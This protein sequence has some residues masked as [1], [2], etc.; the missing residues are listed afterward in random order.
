MTKSTLQ[1]IFQELQDH[2]D[3]VIHWRR[4]LHQH[5]E[6]SFQEFETA[7][8]IKEKLQSFGLEI[9]TNIGGNG[10]IAILNGQKK[11]PT[12]GLRADFDALPINDG[13]DVPYKSK[14][15]GVMHACGHDGHTAALLGTAR[16]LSKY[17]DKISGS[18]IFIFQHAEEKPPGGAKAM[19]EELNIDEID[20]IF[21]AHLASDIPIGK[22][23]VGAGFKMAAVDK[24]EI[25]VHGKGGHGAKPQ[26]TND[27]IVIGSD[28]VN[29]FQKI[30]SRRVDPLDSAVVTLGV[31]HAGN[32]FNV[33]P[34][35]ARLEGTV[36]SFSEEVRKQVK[37]NIYSLVKGIT[38][39]YQASFNI[40]YL[41]GYPALYNPQ[42][43][44]AVITQ[45]FTELLGEENVVEFQT[46]MGAEDF[47]YFLNEKPGNYFKVGSRNH[48]GRTQFPHHHPNF[49]ID[50]R[51]LLIIQET[52]VKIVSHYVLIDE[53]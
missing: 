48:D 2:Q 25:I 40:D 42:K 36:R 27:P 15:P 10:V 31:F 3:E 46:S 13:K 45:L 34:N 43:E 16:I 17:K 50:E 39:G 20:Y 38:D 1:L 29:A 49:D 37:E 23:A 21:A 11:G 35:E 53:A 44:T 6:L 7:T 26:E 24:F 51:A 22:V 33:I 41:H 5:P 9:K 28:L 8:F 47:A 30:V 32:A 12:I 14:N 19:I 52:F 18:I 4:H